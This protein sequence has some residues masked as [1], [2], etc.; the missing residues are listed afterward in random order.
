MTDAVHPVSLPSGGMSRKSRSALGD[1][2]Y[3]LAR[4]R[5]A[6]FS[7]I[8]IALLILLA[9]SAD[10]LRNTGFIE[11]ID[12]QHRGSSL[13]PPLTCAMSQPNQQPYPPGA[14]QF[15]FVFG[16]DA[17]GRDVLSRTVYGTRVSLLVA[18]IGSLISLGL[19][20]VYGVIS[21]YYGGRVDNLMMRIIDFLYGV[22]SLVLVTCPIP[23]FF[24]VSFSSAIVPEYP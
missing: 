7:L 22:P 16:S 12:D 4:N 5:L 13:V 15:C 6:V 19:G 9:L 3:Q 8:F 11:G 2:W 10:L 21:G 20:V 23:A 14:P 18:L 24:I 1:A 17:V